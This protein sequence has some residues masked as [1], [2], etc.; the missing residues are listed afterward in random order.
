MEKA[1]GERLIQVEL[2]DV[3]PS[4]QAAKM[5]VQKRNFPIDDPQCFEESVAIVKGPVLS[6]EERGDVGEEEAVVV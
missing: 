6:R 3:K 1:N 2:Q 4:F 5:V